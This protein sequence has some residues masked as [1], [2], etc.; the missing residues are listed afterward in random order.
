MVRLPDAAGQLQN[1]ENVRYV[2]NARARTIPT[3]RIIRTILTVPNMS[4]IINI[5][6]IPVRVLR[7]LFSGVGQLLLAADRFR[8]V[9]TERER[10]GQDEQ[11]DPPTGLDGEAPARKERRGDGDARPPA[12]TAGGR[13]HAGRHS[14][15]AGSQ[16]SRGRAG[17][18]PRAGRRGQ[19]AKPT[20]F[21]SLDS[22]GNVRILTNDM[23]AETPGAARPK[24]ASR[25]SPKHAARSRSKTTSRGRAKTAA[26][27]AKA[28]PPP[29]APT[30]PAAPA[31]PAD[32][33]VPGYDGL[34]LPS[35]RARLRGLDVA[36]LRVLC[37]H[38]KSG[39]NRADVVTM[40]ERRIAKLEAAAQ[41]AT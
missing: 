24:G 40:F 31:A 35:I 32:L 8:D 15:A 27:A 29:T 4:N 5:I 34:S 18:R 20:R 38:E 10:Y 26:P 19:T 17:A 21:R 30:A 37:D 25:P 3:I 36:Q 22:T 16:A 39:A 2:K 6:S 14:R 33:P 9:G 28:A 7:G 23:P 12:Q 41:D 11:F 13:A 1:A